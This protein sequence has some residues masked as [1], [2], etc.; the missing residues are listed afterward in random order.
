MKVL[1]AEDE[2][3]LSRALVAVLTHE[4]FQPEAVYDGA[5]AVEKAKNEVYD[6]MIFDIMMPIMDGVTALKEIR[7]TGN[8]TPAIFLTAKAEVDDRIVGLESGA[9]D[10]LT[11]PFAMKELI[12]RI[13]SITRR[14]GAYTPNIL[15]LGTVKLNM[16]E[17]EM[18]SE[19][20]IRLARKETKL[21]EYFM[22]NPGKELTTE[23]IYNH[24]WKDEE[25]TG[26]EVVWVYISYLR[27]KLK[28]IEAD[29]IIEGEEGKSYRIT[30]KG[31]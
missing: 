19:N 8:T 28:A 14:V 12:A 4:G 30:H 1:I 22:L 2:M 11:K 7:S 5:A 3:D 21:M 16:E 18:S 27:S 29:I 15:A 20:S 10:Y 25:D 13:H 6:C 31:E 24:V 17:Q 26:I 23:E 9:D